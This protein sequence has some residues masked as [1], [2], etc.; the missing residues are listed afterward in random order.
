[1]PNDFEEEDDDDEDDDEDE[2]F[3]ELGDTDEL[4]DKLLF[5]EREAW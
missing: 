5:T 2:E 3:F 1:M 4:E